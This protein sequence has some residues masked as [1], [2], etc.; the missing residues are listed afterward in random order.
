VVKQKEYGSKVDIWSLGMMAIEMIK[1]DPPYLNEEPLK[2]LDLIATHGTL[3]K[4]DKLS[5]ELKSFLAA[6]LMVDVHQRSTADYLQES[7]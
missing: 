5:K 1:S 4:P 6:C 7:L 3:E 2:A